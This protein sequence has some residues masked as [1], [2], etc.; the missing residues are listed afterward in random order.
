MVRL[1]AVL[2]KR[3]YRVLSKSQQGASDAKRDDGARKV[4]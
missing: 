1:T 3:Y 4:G 2:Q